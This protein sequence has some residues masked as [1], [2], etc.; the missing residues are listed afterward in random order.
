[1]KSMFAIGA[2]VALAGQALAVT[3]FTESFSYTNGDLTSVSGGLWAAHS[4]AGVLPVQVSGGQAFLA[5]GSGTREDVNRSIGAAMGPG[6]VIYFGFDVTMSGSGPATDTYFAHLMQ[7]TSVFNARVWVSSPNAGGDYSFGF[8]PSSSIVSE[9]SSDFTY[10]ST[11]RVIAS[12]NYDTTDIKL[13]I[14]ASM[15]G[16]PSITINTGFQDEIVGLAFR[17]AGGNTSQVLDNVAVGNT[18]TSVVPTPGAMA[19]MGFAGVAATRRRRSA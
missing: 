2:V 12:Y 5:Q 16:D 4:G 14:N 11:Q 19:L 17:Q 9:W 7:S 1:M 18:F 13:W 15:E 3:P 6:D 8:G 10:G